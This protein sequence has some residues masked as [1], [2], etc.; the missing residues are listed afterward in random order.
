M[1][2]QSG[3]KKNYPV[4]I[5]IAIGEGGKLFNA[6][7][8]WPEVPYMGAVQMQKILVDALDQMTAMGF[9]NVGDDGNPRT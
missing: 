8:N 6:D 2:E 1:A 4:S 5:K 7:M 3:G 9:A